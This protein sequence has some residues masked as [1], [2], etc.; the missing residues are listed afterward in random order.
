MIMSVRPILMTLSMN[1]GLYASDD[2]EY[3]QLYTTD[4][5]HEN[6]DTINND[7]PELVDTINNDCEIISMTRNNGFEYR[8]LF[9]SPRRD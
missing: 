3:M 1:V 8:C 4:N 2:P 6:G 7:G 9:I 5:D